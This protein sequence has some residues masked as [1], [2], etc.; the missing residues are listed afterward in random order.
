M[1]LV[2]S[3][4]D[5]VHGLDDDRRLLELM[6]RRRTLQHP[7]QRVEDLRMDDAG[8]VGVRGLETAGSGAVVVVGAV[9]PVGCGCGGAVCGGRVAAEGARRRGGYEREANDRTKNR[10]W[11]WQKNGHVCTHR[12]AGRE[13]GE[14]AV[15]KGRGATKGGE[16][17]KRERER[18]RGETHNKN[19]RQRA[20]N[21]EEREI[22]KRTIQTHGL[23]RWERETE[24]GVEDNGGP[25]HR[26]CV[27]LSALV[28]VCVCCKVLLCL[29]LSCCR[30]CCCLACVE[31]AVPLTHP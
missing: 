28:C 2:L 23:E 24:Q 31:V 8:L 29:L 6:Q 7:F 27:C 10:V 9:G 15:G 26:V 5:E 11:K 12:Q 1:L 20:Q 4:L 13:N 30:C 19:K 14:G 25:T 16:D 22:E 18:R 17:G 21:R 3:G